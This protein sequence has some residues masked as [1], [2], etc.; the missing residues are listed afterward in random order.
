MRRSAVEEGA[1]ELLCDGFGEVVVGPDDNIL[2][3]PRDVDDKNSG[4]NKYTAGVNLVLRCW[5]ARH[6]TIRLQKETTRGSVSLV[7]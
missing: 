1:A 4:Y 2:V 6:R 3:I 5:L 7:P